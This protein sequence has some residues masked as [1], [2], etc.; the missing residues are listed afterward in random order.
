MLCVLKVRP[1]KVI[2]PVMA[3]PGLTLQSKAK[4]TKAATIVNE[5]V[6]PSF[7]NAPYG[8]CTCT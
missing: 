8:A 3:T 1:L 7:L 6:E 2:Y 4:D 5:S